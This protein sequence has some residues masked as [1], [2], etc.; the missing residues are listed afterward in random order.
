MIGKIMNIYIY[1][2]NTNYFSQKKYK[3]C[4]TYAAYMDPS[5]LKYIYILILIG[6][7][8]IFQ[9]YIN[10]ITLFLDLKINKIK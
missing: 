1:I 6:V 7:L 10:Y 3:A 4:S 5:P 9:I 2:Y 8:K